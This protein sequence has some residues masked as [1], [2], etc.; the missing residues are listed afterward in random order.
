MAEWF[1]VAEPSVDIARE[2]DLLE[3][4]L[5]RLEAEYSMFFG[6]R[7]PRPPWETRSRVDALV[8]RLDR[9]APSNYGVRFRFTS[10]QSRF[11][12]LVG[13][14]A[15]EEGRVGPFGQPRSIAE[16]AATSR[17]RVVAVVALSD[18]AREPDKVQTLFEDLVIARREAGQDAIPF[19]Q[20]VEMIT[21]QVSVFREKGCGD[22]AFR[23][24]LKDGKV[25]LTARPTREAGEWEG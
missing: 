14:R 19:Q 12:V 15:R 11:R 24:T 25:A 23:V 8:K 2:I 16:R 9:T 4:E 18:P 21:R 3:A 22:V 13:L 17:D 7:L 20:F 10:L 6:G 1:R 5:K